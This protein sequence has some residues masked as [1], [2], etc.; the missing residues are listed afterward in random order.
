MIIETLLKLCFEHK[1]NRIFNNNRNI[2]LST[3]ENF[4][5]SLKK[6]NY[7][8]K[9]LILL[10][11]VLAT[12]INFFFIILFFF[13]LRI[14]YYSESVKILSTLP[15]FKNINNFILANLLLHYE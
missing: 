10:F 1:L 2:V 15:Y 7:F 5:L 6:F 9:F 11:L 8:L 13:K 14:N 12:L 4:F 3:F